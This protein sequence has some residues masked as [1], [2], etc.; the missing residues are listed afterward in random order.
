VTPLI[1]IK[2]PDAVVYG[3]FLSPVECAALIAYAEGRMRSSKVV[4]RATG[5]AVVHEA[6]TSSSTFLKRGQF[7]LVSAIEQRISNVVGLP[8]ENG[9]G[10][11]ILRYDVGQEYRKHYDYFNPERETTPHHIK[12]GGQRIATFLMYLNTPEGGGNTTFPHAGIS[13]GAVQGNALLFR[14]DTPTP[15]TKT[16]HCGEPV[17]SGVKWVATKWIRQSEFA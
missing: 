16:L 15:A 6:R 11:Q 13:V 17:T 12:R 9:E 14:Y 5:K 8:V 7:D 4:D 3:N 10:M 1:T 2:V